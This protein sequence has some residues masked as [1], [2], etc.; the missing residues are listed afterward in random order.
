MHSRNTCLFLVQAV[1]LPKVMCCLEATLASCF[2]ATY[3]TLL[4]PT[5]WS[6]NKHFYVSCLYFIHNKLMNHQLLKIGIKFFVLLAKQHRAVDIIEY[7]HGRTV[8]LGYKIF[9][10][11]YVLWPFEH[12]ETISPLFK[13]TWT[14]NV[15]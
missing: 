2:A 7:F 6:W 3:K 14:Y 10:V 9:C 1:D 8:W 13:Y 4:Q 15:V 5:Y 12:L 11:G